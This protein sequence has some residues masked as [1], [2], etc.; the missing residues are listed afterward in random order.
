MLNMPYLCLYNEPF[1]YVMLTSSMFNISL[2]YVID[3]FHVDISN[4]KC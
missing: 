2:N 4:L 1:H 3:N